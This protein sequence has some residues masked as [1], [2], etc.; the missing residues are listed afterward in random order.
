MRTLACVVLAL[1]LG[2]P[3]F[4]QQSVAGDPAKGE[5][6]FLH[7]SFCHSNVEGEHKR[8]PSLFGVIGREMGSASGYEYSEDLASRTLTWETGLLSAWLVLPTAL[9]PG[10]KMEFKGLNNRQDIEHMI[11]YL[12]TL[13]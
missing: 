2:T 4:A 10:T 8:G 11:A 3:A 9:V 12:S 5:E 7:C 1:A 6:L 13:K